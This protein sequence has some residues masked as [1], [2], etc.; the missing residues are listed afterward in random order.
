MFP[1]L[2][3][4]SSSSSFPPP[5]DPL[6]HFL[7]YLDL[8]N[9]FV[10]LWEFLMPKLA[11]V[12]FLLV[13][14]VLRVIVSTPLTIVPS[15][16]FLFLS[17]PPVQFSRLSSHHFSTFLLTS[18]PPFSSPPSPCPSTIASLYSSPSSSAR[19]PKVPSL[20]C[21]RR[22][23]CPIF[24]IVFLPIYS[25]SANKFAQSVLKLS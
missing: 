22:L 10:W 18:S 12:A 11:V 16:S 24:F 4:S 19:P 21:Q 17:P 6:L 20:P 2:P 7:G 1:C 3:P 15:F 25:K 13:A 8:I 23:P 14:V 9:L 5:F